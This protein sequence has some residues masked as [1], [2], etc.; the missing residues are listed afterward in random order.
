[1]RALGLE[2]ARE[3]ERRRAAHVVGVRLERE[4]EQADRACP[5]SEPR[6]RASLATTRRFCSS[7]TSITAPSSWKW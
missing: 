1:M 3:H 2:A 4:P 5:A 7:L 6:W